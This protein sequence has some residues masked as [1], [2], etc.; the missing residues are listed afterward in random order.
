MAKIKR[1][2]PRK[3]PVQKRSI[4]LRNAILE[5]ATYVLKKEGPYGFTTNKVADRAGVNIASLYQYYPNKEALLFHLVEIE[6][7]TTFNAVFP[8]LQDQSKSPRERLHLF[9][10]KFYESEAAE[11]DLRQAI[12]TA[13]VLIEDTREYK[14]L[15]EKADA[16]FIKFLAEAL[17]ISAASQELRK[18]A[19]FIHHLV[20]SF[21]ENMPAREWTDVRGDAKMMS[22]M[23]CEYFKIRD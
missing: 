12:S 3:E 17:K 7:T 10:E 23:L 20:S 15:G 1:L 19:D 22:D 11:S 21:S 6:W 18:K 5:A 2:S 16:V 9:I 8:I 4:E 13:G 14:Q